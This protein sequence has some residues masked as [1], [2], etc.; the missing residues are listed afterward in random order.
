MIDY[1]GG[2]TVLFMKST[3]QER[4]VSAR[5]ESEL[6][7]AEIA[8]RA[9]ISQ[10]TYSDLE[11]KPKTGS[12]HIAKIAHV[13]GV[14]ALWLDTGAGSRKESDFYLDTTESELI[15]AWRQFPPES[16]RLII[17]Q[18]RAV[19]DSLEDQDQS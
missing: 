8:K 17:T 11:N 4:L 6:T 9:G 1:R 12:K 16:Q 15:E 19:L 18:F 10:P 2:Y 3:L 13:L 7:Q 5:E 14:R